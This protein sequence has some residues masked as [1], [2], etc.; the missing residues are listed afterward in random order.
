[1]LGK[2]WTVKHIFVRHFCV[3]EINYVLGETFGTH[4]LR[5]WDT[6]H[7]QYTRN[8]HSEWRIL[9]KMKMFV[10]GST[11]RFSICSRFGFRCRF[12]CRGLGVKLRIFERECR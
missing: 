3:Q 12:G 5:S 4:M 6:A 8:L 1:M 7:Q 2:R 9:R 11:F 10:D